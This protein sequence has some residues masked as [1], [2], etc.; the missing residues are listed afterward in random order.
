MTPM[1]F[2][3][4]RPL[5]HPGRGFCAAALALLWTAAASAQNTP[6][7]ASDSTRSQASPTDVLTLDQWQQVGTS[8]DRALAWVATRQQANG[9]FESPD[10]GQPGITSLCI[11]AFLSRGHLPDQGP[12]GSHMRKAVDFVLSCQK[13]GGLLSYAQPGPTHQSRQPSHTA[14]YNHAISSVMLCELYGMDARHSSQA[15]RKAIDRALEFTVAHQK[16]QKRRSHDK[17]GWRYLRR[18]VDNTD[19]DLSITS[20]QLMFL[21]AARNAGFDV[22]A[23][24]VDAGIQYVERCGAHRDG[25]FRYGL[26]APNDDSYSWAMAG[27]G[28]LSLSMAGRHDTQLAREA[29]DWLLAQP[30]DVYKPA[31][32]SWTRY[33]RYHYSMFYCSQAMYQLGGNHWRL[34]YPRMTRTL[35]THQQRDGSWEDENGG[36]SYFGNTYTT[37]MAVL[38]LTVPYQVLPIFQR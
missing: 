34:F 2:A 7:A 6:P 22:P 31:Y 9:A 24:T 10:S 5:R 28:I 37:A 25:T 32:T 27:A 36:D 38:A 14:T 30:F 29:G 3:S 16:V 8:V 17:G 1:H 21:R 23:E 11:L 20:W 13:D 26:G 33:N 18:F 35:L 15:V 19:S 12:Y 4:P